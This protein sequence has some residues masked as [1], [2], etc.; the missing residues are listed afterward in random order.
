MLG[1]VLFDSLVPASGPP[2]IEQL[3]AVTWPQPPVLPGV[4]L[5]MAVGYASG[6]IRMIMLGRRWPV[7]RSL[8]FLAGC[9]LVFATTATGVEMFGNELFSVFMFQQLTLMMAAP[10]LLVLG[11]PGTLLL[12]ATPHRGAG[13]AVLRGALGLL[14]SW[15]AR[16]ALHP[17][18]MI[19]LFLFAFYGIYLTDIADALLS[20]ELGHVLLEVGFLAAGILFTIPLIS[21][22]PLPRRQ[23]HLGRLADLFSEMPL[24]AFFGVV[25]M[26]A[27]APLVPY[28]E[29]RTEAHGLDPITDQQIAGGLAWSYG[30]LPTLII[31]LVLLSRWF[32][33]DTRRARARDLRIDRDGDP[34]LT[35]YNDHLRRLKERD[36]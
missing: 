13:I 35:A 27:A 17:A 25:V 33:D 32:T 28:F 18:F 12:A 24:H 9:A 23:S 7:W 4:A 31:A 14:R 36:S 19:P 6:W 21:A 20:S 11:S 34:E 3:A 15:P 22:D 30:E 10:P 5:L 2:S 1:K 16:L 29:S 26:M 8:C